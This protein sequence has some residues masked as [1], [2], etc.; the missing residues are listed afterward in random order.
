[1]RHLQSR[2]G[3]SLRTT[4]A[5]ASALIR[6][7]KYS[8]NPRAL[9]KWSQERLQLKILHDGSIEARFRYE[10]T[11]CSNLGRPLEYDYHVKLGTSE[12]GYRINE[13][14]CVPAPRDT[15]HTLQCEYLSNAEMFTRAIASEKPLLGKRLD[16]VLTWE[17]PHL[18]SGC[19]CDADRRA[20]KWGLA[21][22]VIHYALV[23]REKVVSP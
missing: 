17:R 19:Y 8:I 5:S 16:E 18:P 9:Q 14:T 11:T 13:L 2:E 4:I 20:H 12:D 6:D 3:K 23:E 10:G 22:E 7:A 15:G 21:F 1:V